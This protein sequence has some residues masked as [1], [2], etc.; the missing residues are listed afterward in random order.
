MARIE[1]SDAQLT[2]V[3]TKH[4]LTPGPVKANPQTI[5]KNSFIFSRTRLHSDDAKTEAQMIGVEYKGE[6]TRVIVILKR[7]TD[8][9]DVTLIP[10]T[11]PLYDQPIQFSLTDP[12]G[13]LPPPDAT[14]SAGIFG[15]AVSFSESE[16]R[17][18]Y[19][20]V[21]SGS[22]T[23]VKAA[24]SAI[25]GH[26]VWWAGLLAGFIL[27]VGPYVIDAIDNAGG[28]K[29]FCFVDTWWGF[30]W[31]KANPVPWGF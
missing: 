2:E 12:E 22:A 11:H 27:A 24:V 5:G 30:W 14:F 20:A 7:Q 3:L 15:W 29:G 26:F 18:Y 8:G 21:T 4:A 16:T 25:I 17:Q 6:E 28:K 19:T 31:V 23:A 10:V 13:Q 9:V 1:L